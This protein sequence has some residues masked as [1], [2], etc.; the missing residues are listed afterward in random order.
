LQIF[1]SVELCLHAINARRRRHFDT[2]E[3]VWDQD[4]SDKAQSWAEELLER[5][6]LEHDPMNTREGY[7]ET[8]AFISGFNQIQ[9]I[10]ERAVSKWYVINF[11]NYPVFLSGT[12]FPGLVN[13]LFRRKT[14]LKWGIR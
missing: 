1:I 7:G 6:V 3:L 9:Q 8:L 14:S 2:G 5:E 12:Y 13:F 11:L 10:C 4:I